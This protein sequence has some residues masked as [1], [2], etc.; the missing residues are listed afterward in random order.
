[1]PELGH[2]LPSRPRWHHVFRGKMLAML[3]DAHDAGRL[4]FFNTHAPECEELLTL[5]VLGRANRLLFVSVV[6][7]TCP[8][9]VVAK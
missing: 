1:M 7:A 4:K 8:R 5:P 9:I 6:S 2:G 3:M